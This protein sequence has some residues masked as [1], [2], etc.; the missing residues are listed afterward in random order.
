MF[1]KSADADLFVTA[2][3]A[4]PRTFVAHGGWVGSGEL[5][6]LPFEQLSRRWRCVTYDHRGTGATVNRAPK[7][8]F[9]TLVDDLF[10]VLDALEIDE[11]VLAGESSGAMVVLAAALRHPERFSG[12]VLVDGRYQGGRSA[13]AGRFIEGCKADFEATMEMFIAACIPEEDCA[14]E[15]RWGKQIVM[16]SSGPDAVQLMECMEPVRIEDR[17]P[18]IVQP[19]LVIHGTRDVIT[20]MANSETLAQKSPDSRLVIIEG[21]GHVPTMTR[22]DQVVRAIDDFFP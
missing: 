17:L 14:A 16:R 12:L 9:D 11:C 18:R 10:R 21:A 6:L 3:G 5:W 4:G 19:T 7:I 2:A 15:R 1:L 22:P 20:P 13:G 8:T